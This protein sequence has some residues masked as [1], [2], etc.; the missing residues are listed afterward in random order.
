MN[1][2]ELPE[3]AHLIFERRF[4]IQYKKGSLFD[5]PKGSL[6]VHSCNARGVWGSGIAAEFK[7]RFPKSF[8]EYQKYCSVSRGT[9]GVSFVTS[10]NVGCLFTSN[11]F[12]MEVDAPPTIIGN[13]MLALRDL[14]KHN[15]LPQEVHSNKFNSGLFNVPWEY[16]EAVLRGTL[17]SFP[18]VE[19]TWTVWDPE[20]KEE[21]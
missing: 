12:G 5:A 11:S 13:T 19:V 6:L 2:G 8:E 7:R 14:F 21:T 4:M 1:I 16:T 18:E 9:T 3:A 10:E 20:L 15:H 17:G